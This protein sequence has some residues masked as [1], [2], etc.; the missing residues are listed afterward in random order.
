MIVAA[1]A[2]RIYD[3][4]SFGDCAGEVF[5]GIVCTIL[6]GCEEAY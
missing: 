3:G 4:D 2:A 1:V 5:T 6:G